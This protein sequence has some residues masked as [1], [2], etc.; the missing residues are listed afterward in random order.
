MVRMVQI[1]ALSNYGTYTRCF[2]TL[3]AFHPLVSAKQHN[4]PD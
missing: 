4:G 2:A 3:P 1:D